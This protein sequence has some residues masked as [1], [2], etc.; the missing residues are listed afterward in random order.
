MNMLALFLLRFLFR[1]SIF[2]SPPVIYME[3]HLL[4]DITS[5]LLFKKTSEPTTRTSSRATSKSPEKKFGN[6]QVGCTRK[7]T[8]PLNLSGLIKRRL[9]GSFSRGKEKEIKPSRDQFR[10]MKIRK[11][12]KWKP[13]ELLLAWFKNKLPLKKSFFCFFSLAFLS[14][15]QDTVGLFIKENIRAVG[16]ESQF[17]I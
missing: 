9:C 5:L 7:F 4:S 6:L 15:L 17:S 2:P 14:P 3:P 1:I 8:S 11:E 12:E 16:A 13:T 10:L